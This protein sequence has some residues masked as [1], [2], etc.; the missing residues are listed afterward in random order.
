[1]LHESSGFPLSRDSEKVQNIA[2]VSGHEMTLELE[3]IFFDNLL[4]VF[5]EVGVGVH[6]FYG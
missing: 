5:V 4:Q 3:S 6:L 2:I 1:M